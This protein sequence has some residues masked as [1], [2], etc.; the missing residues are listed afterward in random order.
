[1]LRVNAKQIW[2]TAIERF[3]QKV[4]ASVF[5]SWFQGTSAL[6]FQDGVFIV[7]VPST[8]VKAQLETR[9][10]EMIRSTLTD[11]IGGPVEVRFEVTKEQLAHADDTQEN[12]RCVH[13]GVHTASQKNG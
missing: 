13:P 4:N 6:S 9:F 10:L 11:I 12:Q 3:K 1:V 7:S 2:Q 5:I 8:F